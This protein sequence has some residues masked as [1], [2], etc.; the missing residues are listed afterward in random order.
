MGKFLR[1][2]LGLLK[3]AGVITAGGLYVWVIT[4]LLENDNWVGISALTTMLLAIAAFWAIKQNYSFRREERKERLLNEIIEWAENIVNHVLESGVFDIVTLGQG[5]NPDDTFQE[6]YN[7]LKNLRID[8]VK[9]IK[10]LTITRPIDL[11][12]NKNTETLANELEVQISHLTEYRRDPGSG[13][14]S[15]MSENIKKLKNANTYNEN[16]I[17]LATIVIEEAAKIKTKDIS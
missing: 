6:L 3:Y 14:T 5:L 13:S 2:R 7:E 11:V 15:A 12:L 10:I 17:K 8:K 4:I 9:S 16:I 1:K